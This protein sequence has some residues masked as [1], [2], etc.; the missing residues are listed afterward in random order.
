M[1]PLRCLLLGLILLLSGQVALAACAISNPVVS[2]GTTSSLS[3]RT[4]AQQA[5]GS[6]GLQC[7][8]I[9]AALTAAYVRVTLTSGS[10]QLQSGGQQIPFHIYSDSG[11][12]Q[13]LQATQPQELSNI[14]LV[15]I[16]GSASAIPLYF[17]TDLG[18]NVEAGTYTAT[19]TLNWQWAICTVGALN[20]C[21]WERSP[22]L[23]QNC[24]LLVCGAPTN[25]G[26]GVTATINLTLVVSKACQIGSTP[27]VDFGS[28]AL[29]SQFSVISQSVS[30]TCTN[31]EGYRVGF[32]NGQHY[33][34]PWRRM[35]N[36]G[37]YLRYNIYHPNTTTIW[38]N[39]GET[40][41]AIGTGNPQSFVFQAIIDSTQ[42][43]VPVGTY[44]DNVTL[45]ISY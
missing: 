34:A 2:L 41:A 18:A 3:L 22:G 24:P 16:G 19:V 40:E 10:L 23:T 7:D 45:I 13:A 26:T 27:D 35:L 5:A 21:V 32:D 28:Q 39:T 12:S 30:V 43:N 44:L 37:S 1:R 36:G 15:G 42:G 11:Y 25:W 20:L 33:Q 9:L 38:D 14:T 31:S 29:V 4:Q 17:R 6:G 8:G